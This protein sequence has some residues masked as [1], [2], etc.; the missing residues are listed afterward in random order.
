MLFFHKGRTYFQCYASLPRH[1]R[2][3]IQLQNAFGIRRIVLIVRQKRRK[4]ISL[5]RGCGGIVNAIFL[6]WMKSS[7][8]IEK[9]E[10]C[11]VKIV[12]TVTYLLF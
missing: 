8:S 7:P 9:H 6:L 4:I 3:Y 10:L 1:I 2:S 5:I 12:G 11:E